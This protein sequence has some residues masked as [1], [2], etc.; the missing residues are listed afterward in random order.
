MLCWIQVY[1]TYIFKTKLTLEYQQLYMIS[2][3][4]LMQLNCPVNMHSDLPPEWDSC[5][6][7]ALN[8][9][10]P[11]YVTEKLT[12]L[13]PVSGTDTTF[14]NSSMPVVCQEE[15]GKWGSGEFL[16]ACP[17][18]YQL[19]IG[20]RQFLWIITIPSNTD[21]WKLSNTPPS[22]GNLISPICQRLVDLLSWGKKEE[23]QRDLLIYSS[24]Y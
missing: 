12:T 23:N 17:T 5:G 11:I 3:I 10:D 14:T 8:V 2:L 21:R 22:S 15:S 20:L 1:K 7:W 13:S 9:S 18:A 6:A 24:E 19:C 16:R 4:S